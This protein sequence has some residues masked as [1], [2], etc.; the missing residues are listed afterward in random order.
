MLQLFLLI[1]DMAKI[2]TPARTCMVHRG[3]SP[4]FSA[5]HLYYMYYGTTACLLIPEIK[6][7]IAHASHSLRQQTSHICHFVCD[8]IGLRGR[9]NHAARK[10]TKQ[11]NLCVTGHHKSSFYSS[12]HKRMNSPTRTPSLPPVQSNPFLR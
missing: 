5:V 6:K 1:K 11:I 3:S 4:I 7:L 2:G 9:V 10:S 12:K 8:S